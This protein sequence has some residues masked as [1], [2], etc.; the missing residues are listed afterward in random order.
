[1]ISPACKAWLVTIA[2]I[3]SIGCQDG[4]ESEIPSLTEM[5]GFSLLNQ[6]NQ[7]VTEKSFAGKVWAASFMFTR[8]PSVCPRMMAYTRTLQK[9]AQ[10]QGVNLQF[11]SFS[12]DPENDTPDVLKQY[13]KKY[14]ADLGSW[15]FLTGDFAE[16]KRTSVEGFR[17]SLEGTANPEKADFGI[18]HSSYLVLVDPELKIRGY[19]PTSD[20]TT[21]QRLLRDAASLLQ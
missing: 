21:R 17:L 11:V 19:Y 20:P 2:C 3:L 1:M 10:K 13:A 18:L 15:S 7:K 16:V 6:N 8:C 14:E 9:Q 4:D 12:V 5:G